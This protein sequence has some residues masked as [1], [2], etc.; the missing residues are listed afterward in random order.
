ML[1]IK[2]GRLFQRQC[3]GVFIILGLQGEGRGGYY[4]LEIERVVWKE[5]FDRS[6]DFGQQKK[7]CEVVCSEGV[8]NKVF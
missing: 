4:D 2:G 7:K 3:N 6:C 8:G 1:F 5:L